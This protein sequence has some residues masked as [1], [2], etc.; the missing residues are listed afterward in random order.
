M[1]LH[2][3]AATIVASTGAPEAEHSTATTGL[4]GE[5]GE[6]PGSEADVVVKAKAETRR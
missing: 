2:D 6:H 3:L 1:K 4:A 5:W